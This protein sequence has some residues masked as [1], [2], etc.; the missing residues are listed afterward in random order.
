[1]GWLADLAK[2]CNLKSIPELA[3]AM[4]KD[5]AWPNNGKVPAHGALANSLRDLDARK[6][7]PVYWLKGRGR[8]F[9]PALANVLEMEE[10][11]IEELIEHPPDAESSAV[12]M[13]FEFRMFP[14]LRRVDVAEEGPFPGVPAAIVRKG[15]PAAGRTWWVAPRGAGKTLVGRWLECKGWTHQVSRTWADAM[16]E[17]PD[18]GPVFLELES[19]AGAIP[20]SLRDHSGLRICVAAPTLPERSDPDPHVAADEDDDNDE[21]ELAYMAPP[22]QRSAS[23]GVP[24]RMR[25]GGWVVVE[26]P[27]FEEWLPELLRWVTPRVA[28]GGGFDDVV[29]V[30]ELIDRLEPDLFRTP[31]DVIEFLGVVDHVG[32]GENRRRDHVRW[33]S[34][35]MRSVVARSDASR[36]A[37]C[38]GLLRDRGAALLVDLARERLLRGLGDQPTLEEWADLIPEQYRRPPVEAFQALAEANPPDIAHQLKELSRPDGAAMVSAL[39][40]IG[41]LG[42]TGRGFTLAP[43]WVAGLVEQE[44]FGALYRSGA[45]GIGALL[46]QEGTSEAALEALLDD[47]MKA[48]W[49]RIRQCAAADAGSP[50]GC[51]AIDGAFRAAGLALAQGRK[52]PL[53]VRRAVWSAQRP[54]LVQ[55][56]RNWPPVPLLGVREGDHWHGLTS[57]GAWFLAALALTREL[58]Q[59]PKLEV[60]ASLNPWVLPQDASTDTAQLDA[61]DRVSSTFRDEEDDEDPALRAAVYRLG[62]D[63]LRHR[64]L[65]LRHHQPLDLLVP[66]AIVGLTMGD[67]LEVDD[68]VLRELLELRCGLGPI[69]AA[70]DLRGVSMEQVLT[71]CWERWSADPNK[72]PPV[73]WSHRGRKPDRRDEVTPLWAALPQALV[74]DGVLDSLAGVRAAW[75]AVSAAVWA[76][77]LEAWEP[78]KHRHDRE[79]MFEVIPEDLAL[80]AVRSGKVDPWCHEIRRILW[81]RM[82]ERLV[83]VVDELIVQESPL[84]PQVPGHAGV[85]GDLVASAPEPHQ[86]VLVE[87]A[88]AW[89]AAPDAYPGAGEWVVRWL[90]HVVTDRTGAWRRAFELVLLHR[91]LV[92]G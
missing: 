86:S 53:A 57:I 51:A 23:E 56:Y 28:P 83:G 8:D 82:P 31:G 76:R 41:A 25:A 39:R 91:Q 47:A 10:R 80:A 17:L 45:E 59:D 61:L 78:R 46:L 15:G 34:A 73:T 27:R 66:A 37:G 68:G 20:E 14:S 92:A 2:Q 18:D 67:E 6:K 84:H 69:R 26:T 81:A 88:A 72:H 4:L 7:P 32:P 64:G 36:V 50:D 11:E 35:W 44:A 19:A 65:L 29:A 63:L 9:L 1:M 75:T 12:P 48:D 79:H 24:D 55:R 71:W 77:W 52:V 58:V 54:L 40:A 74:T 21:P 62:E 22:R 38:A 33:I 16:V 60:P 30:R 42:D 13:L 43:T 5:A 85:V 90:V 3:G 89:L 87:R 70:A 49:T